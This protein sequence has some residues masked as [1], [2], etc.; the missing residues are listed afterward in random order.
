MS[1]LHISISA[2]QPQKIAR[3]LARIFEGEALP[4]QPFP[5]SW[6]AFTHADEGTAI[7]VYPTTHVLKPGLK[8]ID[9]ET[10][11]RSANPTFVHVAIGSPLKHG[12]IIKLAE[13]EG[14]ISR[15]C[16]RGPFECVEVWLEN[17]I[18]IEI[19]D[20]KMQQDYKTGMTASNWRK[21]FGM[22]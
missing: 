16:N 13:N 4:F 5:D 2:D 3:F 11:P 18:L 14:W 21:M 1:L 20:P 8:T 6:I 10:G 15:T 9:L 12:D 19:L 7:E 22:P 17:R